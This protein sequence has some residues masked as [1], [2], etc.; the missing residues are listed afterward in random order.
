MAACRATAEAEERKLEAT[1][2]FEASRIDSRGHQLRKSSRRKEQRRAIH[3]TLP[4]CGTGVQNPLTCRNY[5]EQNRDRSFFPPPPPPSLSLS[6]SFQPFL[7]FFFSLLSTRVPLPRHSPANKTVSKICVRKYA[8]KRDEFPPSSRSKGES[9]DRNFNARVPR[10]HRRARR[11]HAHETRQ[12]TAGYASSILVDRIIRAVFLSRSNSIK[13]NGTRARL[14]SSVLE[15]I[16]EERRRGGSSEYIKKSGI[17]TQI[18][19]KNIMERIYIGSSGIRR[20]IPFFPSFKYQKGIDEASPLSN[21]W[22][23]RGNTIYQ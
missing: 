14:L 9:R 3:V 5:T 6:L 4:N 2:V 12:K 23:H 21:D 16:I 19:C 17:R 22:F 7:S 10:T 1:R 11:V 15:N 8:L 13:S 18:L 20:S